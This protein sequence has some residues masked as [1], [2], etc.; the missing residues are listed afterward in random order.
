L[1][2]FGVRLLLREMLEPHGITGHLFALEGG[3]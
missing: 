3:V 2:R 1:G